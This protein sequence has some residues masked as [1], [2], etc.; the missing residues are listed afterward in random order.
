MHVEKLKCS[1]NYD[2]NFKIRNG[3]ISFCVIHDRPHF[4]ILVEDKHTR[5]AFSYVPERS[6]D[7]TLLKYKDYDKGKH[8]YKDD[9][10]GSDIFD[11]K[12]QWIDGYLPWKISDSYILDTWKLTDKF[13]RLKTKPIKKWSF[14]EYPEF[15]LYNVLS[16]IP[17]FG[18]ADCISYSL[19]H[20]NNA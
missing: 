14:K 20:Y 8:T 13:V 12:E 16:V 6:Y 17:S 9:D 10:A 11:K 7:I 1:A 19:H 2:D 5:I 15:K 18:V 3:K 4:F